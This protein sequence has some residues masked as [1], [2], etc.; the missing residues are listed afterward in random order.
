M[1]TILL[2][3]SGR[4]EYDCQGRIQGT[5][6]VPLSAEGRQQ[7]TAAAAELAGRA[8]DVTAL[9]VGPCLSAQETAAIVGERLGVKPKTVRELRNLD[10][11]LW[12]GLLFDEVK[13]KHPKVFRQWQE[14]PESVCPPEGEPLSA[15]RGRLQK[16]LAKVAKKHKAGGV[17][18]L[19]IAAP[20][21][22][23][24][25]GMLRN[26]QVGCLCQPSSAASPLWE[27]LEVAAPA[28]A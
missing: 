10:Q 4:T 12:Q 5:L 21:A 1:L 8:A 24:L 26:E 9:Y 27:P 22:A 3:R 25:R 11:G 7:A 16:V 15:A 6:D 17:I 28:K 2:V 19:V 13:S 23:V 18:A 20:L 14:Q